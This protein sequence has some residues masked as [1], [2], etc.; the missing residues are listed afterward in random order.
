MI[1]DAYGVGKE[2]KV[3][4]LDV[5]IYLDRAVDETNARKGS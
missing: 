1:N 4:K 3:A 2:M 5:D